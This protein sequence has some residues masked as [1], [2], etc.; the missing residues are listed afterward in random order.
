MR[1]WFQSPNT[2]THSNDTAGERADFQ[3]KHTFHKV[4]CKLFAGALI[5]FQIDLT[6]KLPWN[7]KQS[8]NLALIAPMLS[9]CFAI[10]SF[11]QVPCV[12]LSPVA[13]DKVFSMLI[14]NIELHQ[15]KVHTWC[16]DAEWW[17]WTLILLLNVVNLM[18]PWCLI[19]AIYDQCQLCCDTN[20]T[21]ELAM[22]IKATNSCHAFG[23][24]I[25]SQRCWMGAL[26]S[27][28]SDIW[29]S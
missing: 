2:H 15:V 18:Q 4:S 6:L 23:T 20:P 27:R 26:Q 1:F 25:Y 9:I 7:N 11:W 22:V 10:Q 28:Q 21:A 12:P 8:G 3:K 16:S 5:I 14:V 29:I 13:A 24:E 17:P 19:T